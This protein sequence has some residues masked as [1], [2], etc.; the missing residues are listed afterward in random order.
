MIAIEPSPTADTRTCD[1]TTVT[2]QQLLNSS[3]QHIEDVQKGLF[4]FQAMLASASQRHD[5]DKI[6]DID[7]F[8]ADFQTKFEQTTWWDAHRKLNRHHLTHPDGTP[9]DI[10]LIDVLDFIADCV[11]AGMARS[12]N[13]YPLELSPVL[14]EAAFKNTVDRLKAEVVVLQPVAAGDIQ[15]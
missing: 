1:V 5:T 15:F 9:T 3:R 13:V 14:L 4:F 11:M 2:K 10:N 6:T 7:G 12:G 8:Y